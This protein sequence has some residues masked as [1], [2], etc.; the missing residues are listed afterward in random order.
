ME[1]FSTLRAELRSGAEAGD[2]RLQLLHAETKVCLEKL[3][4]VVGVAR[5][6]TAQQG[7]GVVAKSI[8]VALQA[9]IA[10]VANKLPAEF[11]QQ[12]NTCFAQSTIT[13]GAAPEP[14]PGMGAAG[15]RASGIAGRP[16]TRLR[17]HGEAMPRLRPV[18]PRRGPSFR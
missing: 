2:G 15:L 7:F 10:D 9:R 8:E 16:G 14:P 11:G 13:A 4:Q 5:Q 12:L 6:M 18:L 17:T 3:E 1:E